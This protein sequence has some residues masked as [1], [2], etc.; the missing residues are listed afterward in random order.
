MPEKE[1]YQCPECEAVALQAEGVI[2]E[3]KMT[4]GE[5]VNWGGGY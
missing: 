2:C 4:N 5:G 3:S 1:G